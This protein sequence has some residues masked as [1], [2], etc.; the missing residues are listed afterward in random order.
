M[1]KKYLGKTKLKS[2][3]KDK[4]CLW[5]Y[6][7][8]FIH[9]TVF[10]TILLLLL[11]LIVINE[12]SPK[13]IKVLLS[14]SPVES[15]YQI[16][17]EVLPSIEIEP[18][19]ITRDEMANFEKFDI[20]NNAELPSLN[21]DIHEAIEHPT[22]QYTDFNLK[23]LITKIKNPA[24][25]ANDRN[26]FL[27]DSQEVDVS[28][29]LNE[30]NKSL[31]NAGSKSSSSLATKGMGGDG[32][33]FSRR[34]SD[35]GA[36]TGDVQISIMWNTIDDIDLHAVYTPGNGL[37]DNINWT[38]R[39]GRLSMGM[40]DIDR[41]ANS[42]ILTN[43]PVENIFWHKGSTPKGFFIVYIHFYRSWSG[44]NKIPVIVRLKIGDKF[45]EIK[46]VAILYQSP[47]EI[48]RFKFPN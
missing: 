37:V 31:S 5:L 26:S 32:D 9:S 27:E 16:A 29:V 17:S 33:E 45:E 34:L 1:A 30:L 10:H 36:K 42:S 24:I 43:S 35:A 40:L 18:N 4:L 38:N 15:E 41:N 14:F 8:G 3:K 7:S 21:I 25:Y 22:E 47:Q 19:K 2:V 20:D 23:E 28:Q 13:P 39:V 6:N 48:Y 11:S 12:N 46:C 44:N